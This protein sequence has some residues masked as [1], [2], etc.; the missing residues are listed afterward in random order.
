MNILVFGLGALGTVYSCFLKKKG[1]QVVGLAREP[2]AEII[3]KKGVKVTGIW[4]KH[5]CKLD[6]VIT[7]IE[8]VQDKDFDLILLPV[9]SF[10]TEDAI[11]QIINIISPNTYVLLLQN[12][13][14]NFEIAS[15]F[16]SEEKIMLGRVIFG[17]ET[18]K[19]GES[20]VTVI[21][22]DVILGSPK[23]L[24]DSIALE[25]F[26][27]IFREAGIPTLA[28]N[29]VMKYIWGKIIY[30][31]ALN[32]LG[33]ILGVSYGKLAENN[34]TKL[35]MDSIIREIFTLLMAMQQETLWPDAE[36]YLKDFY[37][38]LVPSTASHHASMLQDIQNGKKTE[39]NA[40]NGSVV[41]LGKK[42]GIS[43]PVNE[44]ITQ[45]VKAKEHMISNQ[46]DR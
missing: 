37:G 1:H 39:I 44:I 5:E 31:S 6:K 24:V 17:A 28:S 21:A 3:R 45:L 41:D 11:R 15:R 12:G 4:G 38:K 32:P 18:I 8:Q 2:L 30:N 29:Q 34:N 10:S 9:K 26:A 20:K 40:L 7:S 35:L 22:D 23:N 33:A 16:I 14:G 27:Q 42:F 43:T 19:P 13:Y 36:T 25:D 46:K